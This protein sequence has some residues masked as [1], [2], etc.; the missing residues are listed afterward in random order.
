MVE[1]DLTQFPLPADSTGR[2]QIRGCIEE[3]GGIAEAV[4]CDPE[5]WSVYAEN[6]AGL[7]MWVC[8]CETEADAAAFVTDLKAIHAFG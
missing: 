2:F 8:D 4:N 7:H 3:A 1:V 6:A 5:F